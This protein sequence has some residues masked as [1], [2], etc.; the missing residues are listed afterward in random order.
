MAMNNQSNLNTVSTGWNFAPIK[1]GVKNHDPKPGD[2]FGPMSAPNEFTQN[3]LDQKNHNSSHVIVSIKEQYCY[4]DDLLKELISQE[5]IS[6]MN[7]M[8]RCKIDSGQLKLD[9]RINCLILEDFN[10]TGLMGDAK[11]WR[12]FLEDG[13]RNGIHIFNNQFGNMGKLREA[14]LGGSEGEGRTTFCLAS[15][16]STFFYYNVNEKNEECIYGICYSGIFL[17]DNKQK[18]YPSMISYGDII[19]DDGIRWCIPI[20]DKEK[21]TEFKK[22]FNIKRNKD[23]P[24]LSVVIPYIDADIKIQQIRKTLIENYRVPILKE[25]IVVKI[26]DEVIKSNNL[27]N[28]YKENIIDKKDTN[29]HKAIKDYLD[30][31][32]NTLDQKNC[33]HYNLKINNSKVQDFR[34]EVHQDYSN[35]ISDYRS[36]KLICFRIEFTVF[37]KKIGSEK[38]GKQITEEKDTFI[39]V[40][41]QKPKNPINTSHKLNDVNRGY[42]PLIGMREKMNDFV[43]T[44]VSDE[45]AMQFVKTGEIANH[46]KIKVHH[47][48]YKENYASNFY[49]MA[50][51]FNGHLKY[52]NAFLNASIDEYDEITTNDLIADLEDADGNL[53]NNTSDDFQEKYISTRDLPHIPPMLHRYKAEPNQKNGSWTV[54]GLPYTDDQVRQYLK[55]AEEYVYQANEKISNEKLETNEV[56]EINKGIISAKNRIEQYNAFINKELNFFPSK[57]IAHFGYEDGTKSPEKNYSR[58]DFDLGDPSFFKFKEE[59]SISMVKQPLD[60]R[61]ELEIT[62]PNFYFEVSGFGKDSER[63][64]GVHHISKDIILG[65]E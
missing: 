24:G 46:T 19:D 6:H 42:M 49:N 52:I 48:K 31:I 40:F 64:I 8:E 2:K 57:I 11:E 36:N 34:K 17:D 35:F 55:E 30:F 27:Y 51:F 15:D 33:V 10:T 58:N 18:E 63:Q 29:S 9:Q 5:F 39:E 14:H 50:I 22:V 16:I 25:Q 65:E 47:S 21:I 53:G 13:T 61:I 37:K 59:G 41:W 23:E 44:N 43:L 45:E 4:R 54:K 1:R 62:D 56:Q 12:S 26:N 28:Y 20:T 32:S 3:A 60:N 7:N 38:Y